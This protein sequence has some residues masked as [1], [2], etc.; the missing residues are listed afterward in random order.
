MT[1]LIGTCLTFYR[2]SPYLSDICRFRADR[3]ALTQVLNWPFFTIYIYKCAT[4][5]ANVYNEV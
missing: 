1:S 4:Q 3:V 2:W 5:I